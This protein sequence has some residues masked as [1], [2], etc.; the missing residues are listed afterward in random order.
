MRRISTETVIDAPVHNLKKFTGLLVSVA[1][2]KNAG[3][4]NRASGQ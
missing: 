1:G 3:A 4:P 2:Q